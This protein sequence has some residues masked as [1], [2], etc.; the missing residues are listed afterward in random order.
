MANGKIQVIDRENGELKYA[1]DDKRDPNIYPN[2]IPWPPN[3]SQLRSV[4]HNR[5]AKQV[6]TTHTDEELSTETIPNHIDIDGDI[7]TDSDK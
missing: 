2:Q 3:Y 5:L 6:L 1:D 4:N 7:D